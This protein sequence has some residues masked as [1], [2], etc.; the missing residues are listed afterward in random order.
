VLPSSGTY[1]LTVDIRSVGFNGDDEEFCRHIT[2]EAQVA[3]IP[4]S[5]FYAKDAPH[6]YAR[7]CFCKQ[8]ATLDLAVTRLATLFSR[9]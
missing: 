3:A 6:H 7:F 5:A 2:R 1:F 4:I 8:D 9:G